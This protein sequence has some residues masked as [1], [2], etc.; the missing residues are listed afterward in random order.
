MSLAPV[1]FVV[2]SKYPTPGRVKTRLTPALTPQQAA[3]VHRTFL[4]HLLRRLRSLNPAELIVCYDPPEAREPF[5]DL[6]ADFGPPTL[7]PQA[8]GDLGHRLAAIATTVLKRH[9]RIVLLGVDSPDLPDAHLH[10]I[11][12]LT[13]RAD[14][15]LGLATD[16]GYWAIGLRQG[17]DPAALLHAKIDWS[18]DRTAAQTLHN[19]HALGYRTEAGHHW[20]DVDEPNDLH[21]LMNRIALSQARD[22]ITLR[23][24]LLPILSATS[25]GIDPSTPIEP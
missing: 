4:L 20:D 22:D 9:P 1:A 24:N 5:A 11:A 21:R 6:L 13:A 2:I 14:V 10:G 15:S 18:T 17:V 12:E 23:T 16:G 7:L 8:T 19:A 25:L 3:D